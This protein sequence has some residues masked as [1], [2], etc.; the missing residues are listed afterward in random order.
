MKIKTLLS[1]GNRH[2]IYLTEDGKIL[3]HRQDVGRN[4]VINEWRDITPEEEDI[5]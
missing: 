3:S 5:K 1:E 2:N 4:G